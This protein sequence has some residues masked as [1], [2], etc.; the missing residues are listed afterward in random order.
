MV[1]SLDLQRQLF[2]A[3]EHGDM[4]SVQ[5]ILD[6]DASGCVDADGGEGFTPLQIAAGNGHEDIVRLL[7]MR[8]ASLDRQNLY[9]WTA[10]MQAAS[11]G[12]TDIVAL[13]LQNKADP[14]ARNKLGATALTVAAH[15][16]HISIVRLLL[17]ISFIDLNET[18]GA[19]TGQ[20]FSPLMVAA[21]NGHDLIL[22]LLMD[23]GANQYQVHRQTGWTPLMMAAA[24]G[25]ITMTEILVE[26]RG[27][28]PDV[29]N[30]LHRT[31]LEI[32]ILEN[33]GEVR[34]YLDRRTTNRPKLCKSFP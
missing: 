31:A 25:H 14:Y 8:G 9:G 2:A 24:Q 10:L 22:N 1:D 34:D 27:C 30:T 15:Y 6:Q 28:D 29:T 5:A 12:R 11:H 19:N 4:S 23:R 16:G 3:C 18:D 20:A 13:L 26:A 33:H 17:G 32:A 21:L 7:L